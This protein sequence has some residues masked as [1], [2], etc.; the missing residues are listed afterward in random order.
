MDM[1]NIKTNGFFPPQFTDIYLLD[2]LSSI[3]YTVEVRDGEVTLVQ[4]DTTNE[5]RREALSS[6]GTI[7]PVSL[8]NDQYLYFILQ[9]NDR[10]DICRISHS[11]LLVEKWSNTE[12]LQDF[13]MFEATD[14]RYIIF[15]SEESE[16]Q[17]APLRG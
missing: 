9:G 13:D 17:T 2:G 6:I 1:K 14:D 12:L 11:S 16:R 3:S 7:L 5:I 8:I 4:L 15:R 10:S